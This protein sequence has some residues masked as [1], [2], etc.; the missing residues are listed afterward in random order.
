MRASVFKNKTDKYYKRDRTLDKAFPPLS[1]AHWVAK[2]IGGSSVTNIVAH[3]TRFVVMQMRID[4]TCLTNG[5]K[6]SAGTGTLA[7]SADNYL[8]PRESNPAA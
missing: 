1:C 5:S 8:V 6:R 4:E 7:D 2:T 3:V